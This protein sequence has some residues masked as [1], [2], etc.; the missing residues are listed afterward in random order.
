MLPR[1]F[2]LSVSWNARFTYM[3]F[4]Q[5]CMKERFLFNS[6]S[7]CTVA[8]TRGYLYLGKTFLARFPATG[9][10]HRSSSV[11]D[12]LNV[13]GLRSLHWKAIVQHVVQPRGHV[14]TIAKRQCTMKNL[15]SKCVRGATLLHWWR[16]HATGRQTIRLSSVA[17]T[18]QS[19]VAAVPE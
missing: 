16:H 6:E 3:F 5:M 17:C 7:L 19:D 2:S 18:N 13:P 15:G 1:E 8:L 4:L 14:V 11:V 12:L 9:A 10:S